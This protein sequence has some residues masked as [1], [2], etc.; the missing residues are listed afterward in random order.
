MELDGKWELMDMTWG[1]GSV[2][3]TKEKLE[4]V[5]AVSDRFFCTPPLE[6]LHD[7]LPVVPKWQLVEKP[8]TRE[9]FVGLVYLRRRFFHHGLRLKSHPFIA[10]DGTTGNPLCIELY[11]PEGVRLSASLRPT[12]HGSEIAN[13]TLVQVG[14][15]RLATVVVSF[16]SP[17]SFV[18]PFFV[19]R[20]DSNI[21][22]Q[23]AMEYRITVT[24][25][26][27]A[28]S[29]LLPIPFNDFLLQQ[30]ELIEPL[31]GTLTAAS[32]QRFAIRV[33]HATKVAV[34]TGG[35]WTHLVRASP[36]DPWTGDVTMASRD[37][38]AKDDVKVLVQ[39]KPDGQFAALLQYSIV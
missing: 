6:F 3:M 17:G 18:L 15:D 39:T 14:P 25:K 7:H 2:S 12:T 36:D 30:A 26:L 20:F 1:S 34:T 10:V 33:P 8:I 22:P 16:L 21:A 37:S 11:L 23:F 28:S 9:E 32:T 29:Q 13:S 38:N 27:S 24:G 35:V 19:S 4:F 31:D 5:P